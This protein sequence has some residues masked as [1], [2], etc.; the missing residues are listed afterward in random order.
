MWEQPDWTKISEI[1][2]YD[3]KAPM[4]FSSGLFMLLFLSFFGVYILL[5]NKPRAQILYTVLFSIFFYYKSS[6]TYFWVLILSTV[7]DFYLGNA[8]HKETRSGR[9][10]FLLICSLVSNLGILAYFKYTDFVLFNINQLAGTNFKEMNI[11]LPVGISFYTFQTLSYSIDIY[12]RQLEPA[13]NIMDFG[14]FVCFFPQLV[15]G[16]IVR[17]ADF[18]PQIYNRIVLSKRDL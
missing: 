17:A 5:K 13:K 8:L 15:A 2:V 14:F 16:P 10:K 7:I 11:F 4:V 3:E 6:G 12:R 18:I 9:R 1:F